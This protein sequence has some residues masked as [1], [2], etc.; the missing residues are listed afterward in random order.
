[1][2]CIVKLPKGKSLG[3]GGIQLSEFVISSFAT[4]CRRAAVQFVLLEP[5]EGAMLFGFTRARKSWRLAE[6]LA[7]TK[8][9]AINAR[10]NEK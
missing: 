3:C 5:L 8:G 4:E 6:P 10:E 2:W 1:M 9:F 7:M